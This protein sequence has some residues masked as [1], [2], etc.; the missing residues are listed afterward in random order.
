MKK[1][2]K[3]LSLYQATWYGYYYGSSSQKPW[4]H[5]K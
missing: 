2:L 3:F 4:K 1:L 5:A